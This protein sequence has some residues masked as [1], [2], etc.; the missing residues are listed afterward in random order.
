MFRNVILQALGAQG[1]LAPV[2]GRAQLRNSDYL[3]LCSDGLSNKLSA[4]DMQRIVKANANDLAAACAEM[5]DEANRRGGEDNITVVL[6]RFTGE[7]LEAPDS[8]EITI[9]SSAST[10]DQTEDDTSETLR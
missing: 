7:D 9:E 1:E 8:N 4:E 2:T 5:I 10:Q 3:L 6:A